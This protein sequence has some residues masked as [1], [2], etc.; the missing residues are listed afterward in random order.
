MSVQT[1]PARRT[2]TETSAYRLSFGRALRSEWIKLATVRSTWWSIGITALL[3]IGISIMLASAA[4]VDGIQAVVSSV[5]F[6]MLLAGILGAIAV[7]GEYS[8]GMIRSTLTAV[9]VRGAVLAAKAAVMAALIFVST[10]VMQ[11]IAALAV[12]PIV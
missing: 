11:L 9:P 8:T 3:T 12:T 5:Q 10:A 4:E 7:T 2:H 6:T 1:A